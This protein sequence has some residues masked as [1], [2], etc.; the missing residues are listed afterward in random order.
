MIIK[1]ID[2]VLK[3]NLVYHYHSC[4]LLQLACVLNKPIYVV[5]SLNI[6]IFDK[7]SHSG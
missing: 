5:V 7:N 6:L 4:L 3:N 1:T 2:F